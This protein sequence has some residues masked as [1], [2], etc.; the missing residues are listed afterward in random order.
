[1]AHSSLCLGM[2]R[3]REEREIKRVTFVECLTGRHSPCPGGT[4]N[5]VKQTKMESRHH[6][7][8]DR[9]CKRGGPRAVVKNVTNVGFK[10]TFS[11]DRMHN[12][13]STVLVA[14]PHVRLPGGMWLEASK[15]SSSREGKVAWLRESS[16]QLRLFS[17]S[18][19]FRHCPCSV[20]FTKTENF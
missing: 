6:W 18:I 20:C 5:L 3:G 14:P 4:R 17:D 1:M 16:K 2:S 13:G 7:H 10:A 8:H 15:T 9:V 11:R 19:I 12:R